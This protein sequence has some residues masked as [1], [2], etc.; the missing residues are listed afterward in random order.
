M[1]ARTSKPV[2][3]PRQPRKSQASQKAQASVPGNLTTLSEHEVSSGKAVLIHGSTGAGKTVLSIHKAPRPVLVLDADTGLDSVHGTE[4]D[5]QVQLW[6]PADGRTDMTWEDLDNFR[7]YVKSGDWQMDYKTIVCDNLTAGQKPVIVEAIEQSI[8]R[9]TDDK[10]RELRDPDIPSQQDWGKVYRMLDQWVRDVKSVKRRGVHVIF[11]MGTREW[12]DENEGYT[13]FMPNLE[14][15][16]RNQIATH[17]DAVG[18]LESDEDGRRL[19]L[20]PSGSM[21]TKVRLPV[22]RHNRVPD[23]IE[24][25]DFDKMIR[26]VAG[27]DN[28]E[29]RKPSRKKRTTTTK[30]SSS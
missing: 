21:I 7:H 18:Y 13:K 2:Q 8:A 19:I 23:A 29:D 1:T 4:D 9:I 30:R 28:K 3:R 27:L 22:A 15:Q 20:A 17:M 6:G 5:D 26:A 25:P 16:E 24:D 10:K 12:M 14:G 11:T